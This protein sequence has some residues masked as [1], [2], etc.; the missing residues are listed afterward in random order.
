MLGEPGGLYPADLVQQHRARFPAIS[1]R[2]VPGTNHYTVVMGETG[3]RA[4][5]DAL[6]ALVA[7][8]P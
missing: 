4:V 8:R 7:T 2:D 6:A 1:C 5:A 3:A